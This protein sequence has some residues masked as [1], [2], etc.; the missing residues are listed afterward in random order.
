MKIK[1]RDNKFLFLFL[2]LVTP[3]VK[4]VNKFTKSKP[5]VTTEVYELKL[6][7]AY[8]GLN[9]QLHACTC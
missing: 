4:D 7:T 5:F 2:T 6:Y 8:S 9:T 3:R 1:D